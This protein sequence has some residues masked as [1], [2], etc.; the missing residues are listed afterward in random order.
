MPLLTYQSRLD[1][2][3]AIK[4]IRP[5]FAADEGFRSRFEREAKA[6]ARLSHPNIVHIYDFGEEG[7]LYYLVMEYID[8]G[9]LKERLAVLNSAGET[10]EWGEVCRIAH[11]LG[12]ALDYAHQQGIVHLIDDRG[13]EFALAGMEMTTGGFALGETKG[14]IHTLRLDPPTLDVEFDIQN[15]TVGGSQTVEGNM[16]AS[17]AIGAWPALR[18]AFLVPA[19]AAGLRLAGGIPAVSLQVP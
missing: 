8:G 16:P 5:E 4:F 3:V 13:R 14:L 19:D 10:M 12:E 11:Q 6:I 7:N 17:A 2:Y 9:T 15:V 18:L 1:R